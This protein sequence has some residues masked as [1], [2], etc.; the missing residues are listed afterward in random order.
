M[1]QQ[2]MLAVIIGRTVALF[3]NQVANLLTLNGVVVD[4]SNYNTSQL[5]TAVVN[6]LTSS[7]SFKVD[8]ANFVELNQQVI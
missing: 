6:G 5:V 7:E 3:P 2:D 8:F 1:E 4:A